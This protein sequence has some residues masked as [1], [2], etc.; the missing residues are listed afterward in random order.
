MGCSASSEPSEPPEPSHFQN[1]S[2]N[3]D[4]LTNLLQEINESPL[5]AKFLD[6]NALNGTELDELHEILQKIRKL[7]DK[8]LFATKC[9]ES[10]LK[11]AIRCNKE[12]SFKNQYGNVANYRL[13]TVCE[14]ANKM[15]LAYALCKALISVN[16]NDNKTPVIT[17]RNRNSELV[18]AHI[19]FFGNQI[20]Q[21]A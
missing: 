11:S 10:R 4:E 5:Y 15:L 18:I 6:K 2:K 16:K 12:D 1:F 7:Q 19:N 3:L 9:Y 20:M 13:S 21:S 8:I 14:N 17:A